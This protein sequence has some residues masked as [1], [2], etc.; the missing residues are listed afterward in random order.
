MRRLLAV[1]RL[2]R[3]ARTAR[4][5]A[6]ERRT[7]TPSI[8][9]DAMDEIQARHTEAEAHLSAAGTS[10]ELGFGVPPWWSDTLFRSAPLSQK[11]H[12]FGVPGW[13]V[14]KEGS[15]AAHLAK[16]PDLMT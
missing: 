2:T 14:G 7:T 8:T 11:E 13:H 3:V 15:A 6:R 4:A 9:D 1:Q 16:G 12:G 5:W 10:S